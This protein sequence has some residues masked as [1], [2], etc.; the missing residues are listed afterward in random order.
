[1]SVEVVVVV[2]STLA[3]ARSVLYQKRLVQGR[4][5]K[6]A[7]LLP[8]DKIPKIEGSTG[9]VGGNT[10][11]NTRNKTKCPKNPGK[12]GPRKVRPDKNS[13]DRRVQAARNKMGLPKQ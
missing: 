8:L 12:P 10:K 7:F 9:E 6:H 2:S 3:A 11:Q 5:S 13:Q 4:S 1:M